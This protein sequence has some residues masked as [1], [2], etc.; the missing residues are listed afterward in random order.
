[1]LDML[2]SKRMCTLEHCGS[3]QK[4]CIIL[5][6]DV[7]DKFDCFLAEELVNNVT[8]VIEDWEKVLKSYLTTI[9]EE[10]GT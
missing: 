1:M 9:D 8:G 10:V 6:Y 7:H 4:P 5:F 3:V 2:F